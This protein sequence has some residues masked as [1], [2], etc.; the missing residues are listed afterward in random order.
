MIYRNSF[1]YYLYLKSWHLSVALCH[2]TLYPAIHTSTLCAMSTAHLL[3]GHTMQLIL[4]LSLHRV[5]GIGISNYIAA[6]H[7]CILIIWRTQ[8][9]YREN[10]ELDKTPMEIGDQKP[11]PD[12]PTQCNILYLWQIPIF[13]A[14]HSMNEWGLFSCSCIASY[15]QSGNNFNSLK[16]ASFGVLS[17]LGLLNCKAQVQLVSSGNIFLQ[18]FTMDWILCDF[19]IFT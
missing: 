19:F 15:T 14:P 16:T 1:C 5:R 2:F 17:I 9:L 18:A 3:S 6:M 10:T 12:Y 7:L 11:A 4:P 13:H 8:P